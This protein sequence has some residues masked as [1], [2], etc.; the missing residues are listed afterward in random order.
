MSETPEGSTPPPEPE[1]FGE[2]TRITRRTLHGEVVSHVRDMIIEGRLAPGARINEV[3]VGALLGVSR[4]P[5]REA[6][7]TLASEGLVEV[8]PAKGAIV[9]RF[10]EQDL[11]QILEV[12]K[13]IEQLGGRLAC[14]RADQATIEAIADLHRR[15]LGFYQSRDRLE[16][17]KLNQA[18]H[19]AIVQASGNA[20]LAETHTM[21]QSRIKRARFIGHGEPQKWAGAVAEHEEMVA[22]LTARDA[23]RLAEVIGRHLD[24]S[25]TRVR[26]AI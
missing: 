15:M 26:D 7:K 24:A 9:R 17:F 12:L 10:S 25:L 3:Q 5:L 21:L 8:V 19:S 4:T 16:Y 23:D 11:F 2:I 18:I 13:S 6:I 14:A 22:A 1:I 20:V